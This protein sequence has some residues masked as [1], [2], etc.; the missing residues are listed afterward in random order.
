MNTLHSVKYLHKSSAKIRHTL[1]MIPI[2][3]RKILK[4]FK[5]ALDT[6]KTPTID[7]FVGLAICHNLDQFKKETGRKISHQNLEKSPFIIDL[8]DVN[9]HYLVNLT[10]KYKKRFGLIITG[11]LYKDSGKF[12]IVDSVLYE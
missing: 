3:S 12:R 5:L 9:D 8:T 4:S 10:T 2:E 1:C 6:L 11:K 7:L